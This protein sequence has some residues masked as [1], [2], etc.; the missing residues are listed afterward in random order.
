MVKK[1]LD[2]EVDKEE[3]SAYSLQD[4]TKIKIRAILER[5]MMLKGA[6][7][8]GQQNKMNID[9]K[10]VCLCDESVQGES[11]Q[12][13]YTPEQVQQNIEIEHCQYTTLRYEPS[14]YVLDNNTHVVI[15]HNVINIARTRLYDQQGDRIYDVNAHASV[16]AQVPRS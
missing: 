14:V 1:Y 16:A 7:I 6:E 5:A 2:F 13:Q 9:L 11:T 8:E 10:V 3:W 12:E 15:H 4:G